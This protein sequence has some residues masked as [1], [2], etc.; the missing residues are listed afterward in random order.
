MITPAFGRGQGAPRAAPAR[1][2]LR[3]RTDP[4]ERRL[5]VAPGQP[6]EGAAPVNLRDR[7]YGQGQN[8]PNA[9]CPFS[10]GGLAVGAITPGLSAF[11]SPPPMVPFQS[12]SQR[13]VAGPS[14]AGW[15]NLLNER[16]NRSGNRKLFRSPPPMAL[17][18]SRSPGQPLLEPS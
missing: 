10:I 6:H 8:C 2:Q 7:V 1:R 4:T 12:R 17:L 3:P 5:P 13:L 9:I 15:P 16:S 11:R 14:P 18:L